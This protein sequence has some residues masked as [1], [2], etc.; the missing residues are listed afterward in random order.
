MEFRSNLTTCIPHNVIFST[1]HMTPIHPFSR[2]ESLLFFVSKVFP[3]EEWKCY[4]SY[5]KC[6]WKIEISQQTGERTMDCQYFFIK[7][8]REIST[9]DCC[10]KKVFPQIE[11]FSFKNYKDFYFYYCRPHNWILECTEFEALQTLNEIIL[12]V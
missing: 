7:S 5:Y 3:R 11:T 9:I 12:L 2:K 10:C 1:P 8:L 6:I 4:S